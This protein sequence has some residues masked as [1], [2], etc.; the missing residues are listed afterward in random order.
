[1]TAQTPVIPPAVGALSGVVR[2]ANGHPLPDVNVSLLGEPPAT[3]TDTA[4]RFVLR[5]VPVG[6]HTTLF[7]HIGLRSV[8]YKWVA[9]N[10]EELQIAVALFPVPKQLDRVVVEA[11]G[12]SRKRGTSSIGGTVH[13]SAGRPVRDADVRLLGAGLST[14]TDSAGVFQ[15]E[16]LAAGSYIVRVRQRGY[17]P[18]DNVMQIVDDDSRS[19]GVTLYGLPRKARDID[20]ASGFGIADAG[21]A[22]FDRRMLTNVARPVL[23]PGDLFRADRAPLD[24]VLQAYRDDPLAN[25]RRSATVEQGSGS[26]ADGD[27]VIV[28]GKRPLFQ[29]LHLFTS[30][31]AQL[32]EVFR[33]N[34]PVDDF[35]VSEMQGLRECRG[36]LDHHPAYFVIWTRAVR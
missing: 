4:G 22:A 21:F 19:I 33:A 28:D 31:D 15:F 32:V 20:D 29:P 11:P 25:R 27:C 12:A 7:R 2:D 24:F 26:S 34:G 17:L 5:N 10:G 9:R 3:R 6:P 30:V 16:L 8:E 23:G 1:M 14:R 18:M 13:D 36:S 35:V